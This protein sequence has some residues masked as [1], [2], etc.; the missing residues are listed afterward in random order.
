MGST[1]GFQWTPSPVTR[2]RLFNDLS[3]HS[4][5]FSAISFSASSAV[6]NLSGNP[7]GYEKAARHF[8]PKE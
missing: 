5:I 4:I 8:P 2:S 7:R 6:R 3:V 1:P